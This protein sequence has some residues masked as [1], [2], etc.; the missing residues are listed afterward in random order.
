M[1][2]VIAQDRPNIQ[3]AVRERWIVRIKKTQ[4]LV[5]PLLTLSLPVLAVW[6]RK[7]C[8]TRQVSPR[9]LLL[10]S[11]LIPAVALAAC[12][13]SMAVVDVLGFPFL[14]GMG[15]V[16]L[17]YAPL[18]LL[19]ALAFVGLAVFLRP[20]QTPPGAVSEVGREGAAT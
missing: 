8:F 13:L 1:S 17:G 7:E 15:Y 9:T 10:W 19:C 3:A 14:A 6:R 16:V 20:A 11:L 18:T 2:P 5:F 4:K 12:C